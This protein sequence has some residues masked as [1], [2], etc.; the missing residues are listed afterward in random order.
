MALSNS[1]Y[2]INTFYEE[3]IDFHGSR[4]EDTLRVHDIEYNKLLSRIESNSRILHNLLHN[5]HERCRDKFNAFEKYNIIYKSIHKKYSANVHEL[6]NIGCLY[7]NAM[8]DKSGNTTDDDIK[9]ITHKRNELMQLDCDYER[10]KRELI[11]TLSDI[12]NDITSA[13]PNLYKSICKISEK[14]YF[15]ED[16]KY[17]CYDKYYMDD[18]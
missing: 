11:T 8:N 9:N 7:Y 18:F 14:I 16:D 2:I 10:Q 1:L 4:L 15:D 3:P 6:S 17:N 12:A 5:L 13:H